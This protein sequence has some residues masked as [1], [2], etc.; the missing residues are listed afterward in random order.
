[1]KASVHKKLTV[2][3][4]I[5][6][7]RM[8]VEIENTGEEIP[9][10]VHDKLFKEPVPKAEGAEGSGVGLLIARTIM[11]RYGGDIELVRTGREGTMF[12]L[13]LPLRRASHG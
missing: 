6:G 4:E 2:R 5:R 10:E 1:M 12:S 7:Q 8:V 13:W 11:R 3:S 9:K